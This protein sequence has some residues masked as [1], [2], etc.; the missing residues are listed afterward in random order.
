MLYRWQQL[1]SFDCYDWMI[2]FG[3]GKDWQVMAVSYSKVPARQSPEG[4]GKTPKI[5][6]ELL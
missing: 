1:F 3:V 2:A 5:L 4:L 6:F